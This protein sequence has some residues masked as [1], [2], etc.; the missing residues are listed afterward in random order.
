MDGWMDGQ[1][2]WVKQCQLNGDSVMHVP[3][4]HVHLNGKNAINIVSAFRSIASGPLPRKN[5]RHHIQRR[6]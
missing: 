1:D 3:Q 4:P 6:F 2:C 5:E